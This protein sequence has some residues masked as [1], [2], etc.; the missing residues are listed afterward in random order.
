LA[1]RAATGSVNASIDIAAAGGRWAIDVFDVEPIPP[2]HPFRML[3]SVL[4]T[5][6]IGYV[7]QGHYKTFYEDIV[8]N[9]QKWLDT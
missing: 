3:D 4:A 1:R 8:S 2:S 5:P 9:I 6:R 7:S